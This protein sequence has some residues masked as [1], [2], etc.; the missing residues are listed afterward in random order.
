MWPQFLSWVN[1]ISDIWYL[2][3]SSTD[4][5]AIFAYKQYLIQQNLLIFLEGFLTTMR[6]D[7]TNRKLL[8]HKRFRHAGFRSASHRVECLQAILLCP[9]SLGS[10]GDQGLSAWW[11]HEADQR[12]HIWTWSREI[13]KFISDW[14]EKSKWINDERRCWLTMRGKG[15]NKTHL[16]DDL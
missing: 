16:T 10:N 5:P 4:T 13:P 7:R 8:T 1:T 3:L 9:S 15:D 14:G 11:S 12:G 6:L 2:K